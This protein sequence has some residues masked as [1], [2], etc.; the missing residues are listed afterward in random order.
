MAR[1]IPTTAGALAVL[2]SAREPTDD[3]RITSTRIRVNPLRLRTVRAARELLDAARADI[4]AAVEAHG[5][6]ATATALGVSRSTLKAWRAPGG[7]LHAAQEPAQ[8]DG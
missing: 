8:G 1:P 3:P 6:T 7:W 2:A 4:T 5:V